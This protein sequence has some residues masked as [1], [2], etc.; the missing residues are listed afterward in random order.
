M[1]GSFLLMCV[2]V[3]VCAHDTLS[4]YCDNLLSGEEKTVKT[5]TENCYLTRQ[6]HSWNKLLVYYNFILKFF[7][8]EQKD[9]LCGVFLHS[10][11]HIIPSTL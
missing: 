3:R 9:L 1:Q 2:Y 6:S 8:F 5:K 7:Y 11:V 4:W 10:E